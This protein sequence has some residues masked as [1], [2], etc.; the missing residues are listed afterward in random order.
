MIND[1]SLGNK[2]LLISDRT[3]Q[4]QQ[5]AFAAPEFSQYIHEEASKNLASK[6]LCLPFLNKSWVVQ[7]KSEERKT[8]NKH[9]RVT[10]VPAILVMFFEVCSRVVVDPPFDGRRKTSLRNANDYYP[11]T[12]KFFCTL[13]CCWKITCF[14]PRFHRH[15]KKDIVF[16]LFVFLELWAE[17]R[18]KVIIHLCI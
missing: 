13:R 2:Q 15:Q 17:Q 7:Q 5:V 4:Q 14:L 1:P 16:E 10:Q 12:P 3:E 8:K 9:I 18:K 11:F 6:H